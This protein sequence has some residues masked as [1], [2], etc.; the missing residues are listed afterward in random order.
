MKNRSPRVA[1]AGVLVVGILI[2]AGI[3]ATLIAQSQEF[4]MS[5]TNDS[6]MEIDLVSYPEGAVYKNIWYDSKPINFAIYNW[7]E[8]QDHYWFLKLTISGPTF[9]D[10][11]VVAQYRHRASDEGGVW[12]SWETLSLG[13]DGSNLAGVFANNYYLDV[14]LGTPWWMEFEIK[15]FIDPAAPPSDG[16]VDYDFLLE[17]YE[18]TAP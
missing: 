11:D 16:P 12:N 13:L 15:F 6:P 14:Y 4:T 18:G 10:G 3:A 5:V 9:A 7:D 2:G 8:D 1:L 17:L